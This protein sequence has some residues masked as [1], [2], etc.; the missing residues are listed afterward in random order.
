MRTYLLVTAV[1]FA[2]IAL[3]HVWRIMF[4]DRALGRDPWFLGI[5]VVC[6]G[7]SAWAFRLARRSRG[8]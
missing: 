5:T 1:L 3:A 4:E 7:L 8:A 6:V 2:V